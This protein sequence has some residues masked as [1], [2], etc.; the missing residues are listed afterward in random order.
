MKVISIKNPYA[1]LI[2]NGVKKL[3]TRSFPTLIRG[4]IGI[5]ASLMPAKFEP[6]E[7]LKITPYLSGRPFPSGHI[8][9]TVEVVDCIPAGDWCTKMQNALSR[10]EDYNREWILGD[11]SSDRFAWILRDPQPLTTFISACGRLGFW[12]YSALD[13]L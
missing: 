7:A 13:N 1:S 3:E 5:H 9:G 6:E 2:M 11:L 4:R 12:E 10:M 8:L